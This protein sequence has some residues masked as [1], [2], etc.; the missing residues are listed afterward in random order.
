MPTVERAGVAAGAAGPRPPPVWGSVT[1]NGLAVAMAAAVAVLLVRHRAMLDAGSDSI[2]GADLA[3]LALASVGT[4]L[5]W[6][7]GTVSQLGSIPARVPVLRLF[8]VQ[9]AATFANHVLPAGC[10][11]MAVNLRFLHRHGLSRGAAVGAVALNLLAGV[12]THAALLVAAVLLAPGSLAAAVSPGGSTPHPHLPWLPIAAAGGFLAALAVWGARRASS[13]ARGW[14]AGTV[15]QVAQHLAVLAAV[16]RSP[17]RAA[18]LWLGSLAVPVLHCL[19]LYAVLRSLGGTVALVPL[20]MAYL[21]ASA[22]A[23]ALPSPGG[24]GALDVALVAGLAA[25]GATAAVAL[26]TVLTYR[27]LTVWFPLL[28]G[29]CVLA[30]LV[31]RKVI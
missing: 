16:L 1:R 17:V 15:E 13:S 24:F 18:Q 19:T 7:A 20:S 9:V 11:G 30:V 8:A 28:P 25:V 26:A 4:L 31:R 21:V 10:G 3:W 14:W 22:V 5:L 27:L 6:T 23:A 2:A 29:A 12:V